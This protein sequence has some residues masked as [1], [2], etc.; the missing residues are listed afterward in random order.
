MQKKAILQIRNLIPY[1]FIVKK[2]KNS[3]VQ[4]IYNKKKIRKLRLDF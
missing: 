1:L 3:A 4:L 2:K